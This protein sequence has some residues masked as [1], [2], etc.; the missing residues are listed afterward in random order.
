M[1]KVALCA[2]YNTVYWQSIIYS[3]LENRCNVW[4][5]W[6]DCDAALDSMEITLSTGG[7]E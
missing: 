5:F 1:H 4:K 7:V 2:N 3:E 6:I